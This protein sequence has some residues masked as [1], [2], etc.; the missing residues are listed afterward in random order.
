MTAQQVGNTGHADKHQGQQHV[1]ASAGPAQQQG[2]SRFVDEE[3]A[4]RYS[5]EAQSRVAD[6]TTMP[7]KAQEVVAGERKTQRH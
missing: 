4:S 1:V 3:A 5:E 7:T 2:V 6:R